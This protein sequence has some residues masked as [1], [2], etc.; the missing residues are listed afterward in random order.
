MFLLVLGFSASAQLQQRSIPKNTSPTPKA[1]L[2]V[3]DPIPALPFWDDFSTS[4][5]S[6]DPA[7]WEVGDDVFIN[8]T[9]PKGAPS[10]NVATFDGANSFGGPHNASSERP[11]P[12]DSLISRAID[13]TSVVNRSS[14]LLTFFWQVQGNGEIP[15]SMDSLRL[16]FMASD[17]TWRTVFSTLGGSGPNNESFQFTAIPIRDNE[18]FHRNFRMKFQSFSSRSGIFDTWH[19]DYVYL[20]E[21]RI[22]TRL[23]D[24]TISEGPGPL[25]GDF[26]A[27]PIHHY[28]LNPSFTQQRIL[29]N[30]LDN[31]VHP[32][33]YTHSIV[34]LI[35]GDILAREQLIGPILL[36]NESRLVDGIA[37]LD[38]T[39]LPEDSI[40]L[41]S[42]FFYRTGDRNLFEEVDLNGDTLFLD[43]DLKINDTIRRRYELHQKYAYDDGTAEFAAGL[44]L[45]QGQLAI[46]YFIPESDTLSHLELYFPSLPGNDG[47]PLDLIIWRELSEDGEIGRQAY[48]VS[49][50][51]RRD[52][53]EEV[54]LLPPIVVSDTFY[55]G[56][57]QFTDNYIG[58][59][60]DRS[61][62]VATEKVFF[63]T[64]RTWERNT[65]IDGALMMR[66]IFRPTN[67]IIL[68]T[69]SPEQEIHLFPNPGSGD[70]SISGD[71]DELVVYNVSGEKLG[72]FERTRKLDLS[73][74]R[75]GLYILRF[76]QA[77]QSITKKLIIKE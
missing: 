2:S 65:L 73:F 48:S 23:L 20:N 8:N 13:M 70:I 56:Y 40:V 5:I 33:D 69:S 12:A 6:P 32:L 10:I 25:F 57:Q 22:R 42:E 31:T 18:F 59:G 49:G 37:S 21:N 72:I 66:P 38:L 17:S 11:G 1:S 63:N 44:N 19:I 39:D 36:P 46:Q 3:E 28:L 41:E 24:R 55:I 4:D 27:V 45:D 9:L 15:E 47:Q 30:N 76:Q 14:V 26:Y 7:L 68:S 52:Q 75:P 16:Q 50:A 67:A 29:V 58:I 51:S 77:N 35:N 64:T 61:N 71:Y 43:I 74:L 60:L 53:F 62:N 34:N 54:T